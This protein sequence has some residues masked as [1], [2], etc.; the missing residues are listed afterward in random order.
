MISTLKEMLLNKNKE[1]GWLMNVS[2][3]AKVV[4]V[5][6]LITASVYAETNYYRAPQ[7]LMLEVR[8]NVKL[9]EAHPASANA[10]FEL[11]MSYAYTGQIEK[12][13]ATLRKIP[14][15]DPNYS[16]AVIEKYGN[17]TKEDP[18]NWKNYFKLAFGYYFQKNKNQTLQEFDNVLKIDPNHIWAMGFKALVLGEMGREDETIELCRRALEI[19][20]NATAIHFLL[21]EGYRRKGWYW[22]ATLAALKVGRLKAAEKMSGYYAD[23]QSE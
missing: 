16:V 10:V 14:D 4:V 20:P 9:A 1:K 5:F 18:T 23:G 8:E 6:G 2:F 21:A 13:W 7:D 22:K 11:A 17:L 19:E 15:I 12:G 3:F